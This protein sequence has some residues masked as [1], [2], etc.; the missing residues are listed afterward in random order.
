MSN[1]LNILKESLV[2]KQANFDL[3]FQS[4]MDDVKSANG[5]PLND[6][7]DG[8][9]TLSRWDRQNESLRNLTASIKKTEEAID[10]EENKQAYVSMF[11][12]PNCLAEFLSAGTITQWRK[13]PNFFFVNGVEKARIH[14]L[15]DG[16]IAHR[17]LKEIPNQEQYAI[18]RDVFNAAM[19]IQ[20]DATMQSQ[21][22]N[23]NE[24]K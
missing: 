21:A 3:K 22:H 11:E 18:F 5:Q 24:Q 9:K 16:T 15:D 13:H 14:V 19:Q 17:Y 6:K 8:H 1:R 23:S 12:V 7:R 4:H 10:R 2:K 20:R